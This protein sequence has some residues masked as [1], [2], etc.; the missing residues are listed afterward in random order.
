MRALFRC[1]FLSVVLS[2]AL[3]PVAAPQTDP[4]V[5][6]TT[7]TMFP[8]PENSRWWLSGQVNLIS[9]MHG[10]FTSPYQGDNSLRPDS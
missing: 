1:L 2:I 7:T 6:A 9:Q 3:A 8:H 5:P 10:R 4:G